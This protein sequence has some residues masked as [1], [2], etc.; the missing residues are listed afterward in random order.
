MMLSRFSILTTAL[1][2]VMASAAACGLP[3]QDQAQVI[4]DLPADVLAVTSTTLSAPVE[5]VSDAPFEVALYWH[6]SDQ[7]GRL[8]RIV[9]QRTTP[10]TPQ[11]AIEQLIVG[12][13]EQELADTENFNLFGPNTGLRDEQ[14]APVVG[15]PEAG[16]VTVSVSGTGFRDLP[17]KAN[18]AAE[19]VCTLTEFDNI[20]GVIV[21]DLQPEPIGLVGTNSESIEGP[22][23]RENFDGCITADQPP[24]GEGSTTT[25]G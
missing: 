23:R 24:E 7:G 20:D 8:I 6:E 14:L 22:A 25:S 13:T 2:G 5:V 19:L 16:I 15:V 1:V 10:P 9:R 3:E 17:N 18:A 4:N 21:R 11:E 12:P